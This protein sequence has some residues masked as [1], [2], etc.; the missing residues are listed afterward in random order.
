[1]E[2]ADVQKYAK[3]Y[4]NQSLYEDQQRRLMAQTVAALSA[5]AGGADDPHK[6][7]PD[8]LERFRQ[9]V[10]ALRGKLLVDR[11]FGGGLLKIYD[12]ALAKADATRAGL[13]T[14][15]PQ[16]CVAGCPGPFSVALVAS[17][18]RLTVSSR[19]SVLLIS[20]SAFPKVK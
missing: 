4:G 15:P 3:L 11:Q 19:M 16:P 18:C 14:N 2:Y 1:M 9:S 7:P 12:E 6:A 17:S 8:D 13:T 20:C 10:M 5:L